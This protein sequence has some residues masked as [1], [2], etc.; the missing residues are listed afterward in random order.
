MHEVGQL[1]VHGVPHD[2]LAEKRLEEALRVGLAQDRELAPATGS[3]NSHGND[4]A[5]DYE[6]D[7]DRLASFLFDP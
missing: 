7:A 3:N 1:L 6:D 5:A 2:K 4:D